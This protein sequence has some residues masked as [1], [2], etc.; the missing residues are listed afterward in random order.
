ME[1][2]Q[3]SPHSPVTGQYWSS[4]LHV[5]PTSSL[6]ALLGGP[7]TGQ[8]WSSWL[9]VYPTSSLAGWS[10]YR[11]VLII[12][13]TRVSNQLTCW[14]VQLQV[15]TDHL[16]YT[17][18]QPA[19]LLDGPVTGQYWS[20]WLHVYPTSSLAGWSCYRSVLIILITRV[21]NQ[22]TC[23]MVQLQVSTDH[24]DYTC[25]QPAHLL[26]GPVTGQYW[27]SWLHVYPTSSLAGWSSYRSVLIIL[28]T[29]VSNQL[30]CWMVL[31]QVSTDYL[32]YTCIQPAHL[33][34]GPV[35]GQYW[36]SWLHVYPTSSLAGWSCYRSVLIILI[37]RVS[38]QLTCWMVLLQVSSLCWY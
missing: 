9:H 27:S 18:I 10:C 36:S 28:I 33:L 22:L 37:T 26:G 24:L 3:P 15:S 34:D 16:D 30:T 25:I 32:D 19:H 20:S 1:V 38:N 12:L 11:S 35:T 17:C 6:A 4:W 13:I 5:Y 8:Y 31:L 2:K 14:M 21:S 23:W 29:R 7:V